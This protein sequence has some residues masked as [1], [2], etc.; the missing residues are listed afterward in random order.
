MRCNEPVMTQ[1]I[2]TKALSFGFAL[3]VTLVIVASLD[4]LGATDQRP[5]FAAGN[6]VTQTARVTPARALRS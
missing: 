6:G 3:M 5:V 1:S 4:E 2:H